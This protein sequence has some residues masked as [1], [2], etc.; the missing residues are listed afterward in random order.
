M[1][2]DEV[3]LVDKESKFRLG[4]LFRSRKESGVAGLPVLSVTMNDGL[5]HRDTLD[6]KTDGK[7][8][9][10]EHLLIRKGDLAY[11]MMRMWQGLRVQPSRMVSSVLRTSLSLLATP[12]IRHLLPTGSSPLG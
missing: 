9:P 11:N 6:R 3:I 1:A 8:A 4:E 2:E 7:L 10:D 5:V 12:L